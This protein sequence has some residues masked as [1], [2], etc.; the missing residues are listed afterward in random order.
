MAALDNLQAAD[1]A[2]KAEADHVPGRR[3]RTA[4]ERT[5]TRPRYRP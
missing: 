1:A 3:G 5:R 2:L 4:G